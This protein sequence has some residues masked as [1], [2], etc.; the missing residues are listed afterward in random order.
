MSLA[1]VVRAI[2]KPKSGNAA[3]CARYRAKNLE[4]CRAMVRASK[5]KAKRGK[6]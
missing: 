6:A 5:L 4:A 2:V 3:A 1:D